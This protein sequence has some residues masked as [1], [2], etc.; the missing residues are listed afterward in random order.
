MQGPLSIE[1][2]ILNDAF[3]NYCFRKSPEDIAYYEDYLRRF[4]LEKDN[5]EEAAKIVLGLKTMLQAEEKRLALERFQNDL[6]A[7]RMTTSAGLPAL[8]HRRIWKYAAA[9][10]ILITLGM[11]G[12]FYMTDPGRRKEGIA[13]QKEHVPGKAP[14]PV[15]HLF[16]TGV[17]E[18]K[19]IW[20]PDSTEVML[21]AET[22]LRLSDDFGKTNRIVELEGEALFSVTRAAKAPFIVRLRTLDVTVLGTVFNIKS[23]ANE[24]KVETSLIRGKLEVT[25]HNKPGKALVLHPNQ[26]VVLATDPVSLTQT[27]PGAGQTVSVLPLTINSNGNSIVE[28]GWTQDR[29]EISD[30]TLEELK[31]KLERW[32]GVDIQ[33]SDETVRY[34]KYTA[35]FEREDIE[36]VL[37]ALA[38]SLPFHYTINNNHIMISK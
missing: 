28:T 15:A 20:L 37:K 13:R 2:L 25:L 6:E 18:H 16:A 29:L 12:Y 24:K 34:Y 21:N 36:E 7:R 1:E 3:I 4:P 30:E 8:R 26:K 31:P 32:Y 17:A 11:A 9:S 14:N 22:T 23:Y 5:V 10:V 27:K 35:T 19:R 38:L 33:F